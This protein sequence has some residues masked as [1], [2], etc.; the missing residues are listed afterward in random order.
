MTPTPASVDSEGTD[1]K[2]VGKE[3]Q[4][5]QGTSHGADAVS[6]AGTSA[7]GAA[8]GGLADRSWKGAGIGAGVGSAVGLAT[9]LLDARAGSGIATGLDDRRDLRSP[10]DHRLMWSGKKAAVQEGWY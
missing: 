4:V 6:I 8:L 10:G 2:V 1:Q 9:V 7:A 3:S 5:Q